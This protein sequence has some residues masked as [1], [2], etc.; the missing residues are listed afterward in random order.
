MF[1]SIE[2]KISKSHRQR[3]TIRV[4]IFHC[5][6]NA[7]HV[8]TC[9]TCINRLFYTF[10]C[11]IYLSIFLFGFYFYTKKVSY[12]QQSIIYRRTL[13]EKFNGESTREKISFHYS[14][15][16]VQRVP[17][18]KPVKMYIQIFPFFA[19]PESNRDRNIRK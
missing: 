1:L 14:L 19:I 6:K 3:K 13:R 12:R 15:E 2:K 11:R 8:E 18:L 17:L 5:E 4:S 10:N 9:C 16:C 7:N